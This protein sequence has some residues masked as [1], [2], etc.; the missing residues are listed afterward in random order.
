[1]NENLD[2]LRQFLMQVPVATG[3]QDS[4]RLLEEA[5]APGHKNALHSF[6]NYDA[7]DF[8]GPTLLGDLYPHDL[9]RDPWERG[10]H[11]RL[12]WIPE[13]SRRRVQKWA[14]VGYTLDSADD[15][16]NPI[17]GVAQ[18][19]LLNGD[20]NEF[21]RA[22]CEIASDRRH[23][24]ER[25]VIRESLMNRRQAVLL[26]SHL[27]RFR[28]NGRHLQPLDW[29]IVTGPD[30]DGSAREWL[31]GLSTDG[32]LLRRW[33]GELELA[34]LGADACG[35]IEVFRLSKGVKAHEDQV[36]A[37][38]GPQT[39]LPPRFRVEAMVP[40]GSPV[41]PEDFV[42]SYERKSACKSAAS[43]ALNL[44]R[45]GGLRLHRDEVFKPGLSYTTDVGK[46]STQALD[47]LAD[48]LWGKLGGGDGSP[49]YEVS[50]EP[51]SGPYALALSKQEAVDALKHFRAN[52]FRGATALPH[53]IDGIYGSL[54]YEGSIDS[55][56]WWQ[57]T[58]CSS[59]TV[60]AEMPFVVTAAA[61][62]ELDT[63]RMDEWS[64]WERNF[65]E[66]AWKNGVVSA[67]P[68]WIEKR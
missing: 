68:P 50:P 62:F 39:R 57:T 11:G 27:N 41:W 66:E 63:R 54:Q 64:L 59:Q 24:A 35:S 60:P 23:L 28:R 55:R 14:V 43:I 33:L 8:H 51:P 44:E 40:R 32:A 67:V 34:G 4:V 16:G 20:R 26:T 61:Q 10:G 18:T 38:E 48:E 47:L 12:D 37:I 56:G 5:F 15:R 30:R 53:G 58:V 45:V 7:V 65:Y 13:G 25:I 52:G 19:V 42:L 17:P 36:Y 6:S 9:S 3:F 29:R 2:E 22:S 1:M 46:R 49:V 21:L 31:N